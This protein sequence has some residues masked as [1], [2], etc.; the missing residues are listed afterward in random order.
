MLPFRLRREMLP[1]LSF[2]AP[3]SVVGEVILYGVRHD[4]FLLR[5]GAENAALRR[6]DRCEA[7]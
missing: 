1:L 2:F 5:L 3:W 4:Q 7:I 6:G